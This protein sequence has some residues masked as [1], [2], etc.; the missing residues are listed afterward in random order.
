MRKH[1]WKLILG[2]VIIAVVAIL[3]TGRVYLSSE[4]PYTHDGENHLARFANYKLALKQG[5]FPPRL[6][7]NLLNGYSYPSL[8]QLSQAKFCICFQRQN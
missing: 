1:S 8:I 3:T 6:A 4:F 7:P 2:W 5:Q